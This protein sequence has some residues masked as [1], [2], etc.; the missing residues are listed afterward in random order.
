MPLFSIFKHKKIT[1][2]VKSTKFAN[3]WIKNES[4]FPIFLKNI[5]FWTTPTPPKCLG[6][7]WSEPQPL[8]LH[9]NSWQLTFFRPNNES[10][11]PASHGANDV[12]RCRWDGTTPPLARLQAK[13]G[14]ACRSDRQREVGNEHCGAVR[15][16]RRMIMKKRHGTWSWWTDPG[17][18][19]TGDGD[20]GPP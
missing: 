1:K 4:I 16:V 8:A 14:A 9:T 7:S 10:G 12:S 17:M 6:V 11:S 18:D 19:R 5:H 2:I 3:F 15:H 13:S 20:P